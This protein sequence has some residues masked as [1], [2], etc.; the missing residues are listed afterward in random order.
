MWFC[1]EPRVNEHFTV[2]CNIIILINKL[3][4]HT[5]SCHTVPGDKL[6]SWF[7]HQTHKKITVL[8]FLSRLRNSL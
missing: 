3:L 4:T 1:E 5:I 2:R 8:L 7:I 6:R